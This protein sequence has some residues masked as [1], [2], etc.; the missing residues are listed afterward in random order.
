M[1]LINADRISIKF[2][3]SIQVLDV[4]AQCHVKSELGNA[5]SVATLLEVSQRKGGRATLLTCVQSDLPCL[6]IAISVFCE[7]KF[8]FLVSSHLSKSAYELLISRPILFV[9]MLGI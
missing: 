7:S 9:L 2:G 8:C 4:T 1:L 3:C 5:P 6:V